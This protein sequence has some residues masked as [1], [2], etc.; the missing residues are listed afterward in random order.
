LPFSLFDCHGQF[1]IT[2]TR[3]KDMRAFIHKLCE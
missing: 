2:T 3:D 1:G